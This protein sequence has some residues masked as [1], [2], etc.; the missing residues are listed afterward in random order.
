MIDGMVWGLT[1]RVVV[2]SHVRLCKIFF[3]M[4]AFGM[5]ECLCIEF[6]FP[7]HCLS[8]PPFAFFFIHLT[9]SGF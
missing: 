1:S 5:R 6:P 3:H 4:S 8:K 7:R 9:F 2:H